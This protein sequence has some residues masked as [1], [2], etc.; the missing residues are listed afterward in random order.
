MALIPT[1]LKSLY[2]GP[3]LKEKRH[4]RRCSCYGRQLSVQLEKKK[5]FGISRYG[6]CRQRPIF[7][8]YVCPYSSLSS[9]PR[10]RAIRCA[11]H[12]LPRSMLSLLLVVH[13]DYLPVQGYSSS[14]GVPG[15]VGSSRTMESTWLAEKVEDPRSGQELRR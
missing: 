5:F 2:V 11:R 1:T 3:R 6:V 7:R 10:S 8:V 4:L 9:F 15:K 14:R 13:A 12:P